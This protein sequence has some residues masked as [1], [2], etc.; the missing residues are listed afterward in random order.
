MIQIPVFVNVVETVRPNRFESTKNEEYHLK[1]ARWCLNGLRSPLHVDYIYRTIVYWSFYNNYQWVLNE[2]LKPF[3]MDESG[4]MRNRVKWTMN[5]IKPLVDQW[6]G[7]AIRMDFAARAEAVSDRAINRRETALEEYKFMTNMVN[8]KFTPEAGAYIK[9]RMPIGD[10]VKDTEHNFENLWQDDYVKAINLLIK[11]IANHNDMDFAKVNLARNLAVSGI[12]VEKG[13]YQNGHQVWETKDSLNFFFDRSC[14]RPDLKDAMYMGEINPMHDV[15]IFER[16]QVK[17]IKDRDFI[18]NA[19]NTANNNLTSLL[20]TVFGTTGRLPVYEVYWKD[21]EQRDYGYVL[22]PYGYPYFTEINKKNEDGKIEGYT[23]KDLIDPP[24]AEYTKKILGKKK[25]A[26]VYVDI[27]RFC[28]F[29]PREVLG[30]DHDIALDWGVAP[31]QETYLLDPSNVEF[32][33]KVSCVSYYNGFILSPIETTI[34]P[35]RFLNRLASVAESHIN[36]S[37]GSSYF[38]DKSFADG[39]DGEESML[40]NMNLSKPVGLDGQGRGINNAVMPYGNEA[41]ASMVWFNLMG[42]M[43]DIIKEVTGVNEAMAG[44]GTDPKT[45]VGTSQLNIRQG[46][47]IQEPFYYAL[48]KCL[49]QCYQSMASQGK[50]IYADSE[51]ELAIL[52]GDDFAGKLTITKDMCNEDFRVN[53]VES[54]NEKQ[55]IEDGNNLLLQLIQFQLIAP[56]QLSEYWGKTP[57][58]DIGFAIRDYMRQKAVMDKMRAEDAQLQQEQQAQQEQQ[59]MAAQA[60]GAQQQQQ[61]E[62]GENEAERQNYLDGKLLDLHGTQLKAQATQNQQVKQPTNK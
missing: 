54:G 56:E 48:K 1:Y 44:T 32:P 40:R 3:L 61:I 57:K 12:C 7:N 24:P 55:D 60:A 10:T 47:I 16:F 59:M 17:N 8:K 43:K 5:V 29:L 50:R 62:L 42:Q 51:R 13:F 49:L 41:G 14:K 22:D 19:A 15:D 21:C 2:D 28:S 31:Y 53:I 52:V 23:D 33:Y 11:G 30:C 18:S 9:E 46:T 20:Q 25:K 58:A 27:L 26:K 4:D 39:Q 34:A 36:N 6:V 45:L 35:Q 38:Y 37:R